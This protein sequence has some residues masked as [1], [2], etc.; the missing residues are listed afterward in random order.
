MSTNA[1]VVKVERSDIL[2]HCELYVTENL[3]SA[4]IAMALIRACSLLLCLRCELLHSVPL[5]LKPYRKCDEH[6]RYFTW[7]GFIYIFRTFQSTNSSSCC[8]CFVVPLKS[9][10]GTVWPKNNN[11]LKMLCKARA[12]IVIFFSSLS[13][14]SDELQPSRQCSCSRSAAG[15]YKHP[16]LSDACIFPFLGW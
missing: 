3:Q 6:T 15:C 1:S 7:P 4:E 10:P 9:I 13:I 16:L 11:S 14:D 8:T 12:L 2:W 5:C